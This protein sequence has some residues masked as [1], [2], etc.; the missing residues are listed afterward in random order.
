[1]SFLGLF[2]WP[3]SK[4][5]DEGFAT[6]SAPSTSTAK[7]IAQTMSNA[8]KTTSSSPPSSSSSLPRVSPRSNSTGHSSSNTASTMSASSAASTT[9]SSSTA[10]SSSLDDV[11][12][13]LS[14]GEAGAK[15]QLGVVPTLIEFVAEMAKMPE[16]WIHFPRD[17]ELVRL[18]AEQRLAADSREML[19]E[20]PFEMTPHRLQH[21]LIM[22]KLVPR[23]RKVRAEV[24]P[25][26]MNELR[27][28][29]IYFLLVADA[30]EKSGSDILLNPKAVRRA[31]DSPTRAA[32][33]ASALVPIAPDRWSLRT[34]HPLRPL[35]ERATE[36]MGIWEFITASEHA[37]DA[38]LDEYEVV[39]Y[40]Q[41]RYLNTSW[42]PEYI[43][44]RDKLLAFRRDHTLGVLARRGVPEWLGNGARNVVWRVACEIDD[45]AALQTEVTN[46][47]RRVFGPNVPA[48]CARIPTF[49]GWYRPDQHRTLTAP[50]I[51][52]SSR[53]L[54]ALALDNSNVA[55][56]PQLPDLCLVLMSHFDEFAVFSVCARLLRQSRTVELAL[57]RTNNNSNSSS[58]AATAPTV[59]FLACSV[60]AADAL[61]CMFMDIVE[62]CL[63]D[64][65]E[66]LSA[67]RIGAADFADAWLKRF[68]VD[69]LPVSVVW[70]IVDVFLLEG[71]S[72]LH[73][74]GVALLHLHSSMIFKCATADTLLNSLKMATR[75]FDN[76]ELLMETAYSCA[77]TRSLMKRLYT[78]HLNAD[79]RTSALSGRR[80]PKV[81]SPRSANISSPQLNRAMMT[82]SASVTLPPS[83]AAST[84]VSRSRTCSNLSFYR[85][86]IRNLSRVFT[87]QHFEVLWNWLPMQY[88][89][90][91]PTRIFSNEENG[92]SLTTFFVNCPSVIAPT[93]LLIRTTDGAIFGAYV[94]HGWEP[95]HPPRYYGNGETF[96]FRM[97]PQPVIYRW[98]HGNDELFQIATRDY[99][100]VGGNALWIDDEMWQGLSEPG[101]TFGNECLV[102]AEAHKKRQF[103]FNIAALEVYMFEEPGDLTAAERRAPLD[104]TPAPPAPPPPASPTPSESASSSRASSSASTASERG[105]SLVRLRTKIKLPS[106]VESQPPRSVT[107]SPRGTEPVEV[108]TRSKTPSLTSSGNSSGVTVTK[109][110]VKRRVGSTALSP[111]SSDEGSTSPVAPTAVS[112]DAAALRPRMLSDPEITLE[113]EPKP[114]AS[115]RRRVVSERKIKASRLQPH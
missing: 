16:T 91:E 93:L 36:N 44:H 113:S 83:T 57:L 2:R 49:G 75:A 25:R 52:A 13:P 84:A 47:Y 18:A 5:G 90:M 43:E 20:M 58:S 48:V 41:S 100:A 102:S 46:T 28:W 9:S 103:S 74:V 45:D 71:L 35:T 73:T 11:A 15:E 107:P 87:Q 53:I 72:V 66:H 26:H 30:L 98:T 78:T 111:R 50:Q 89:G 62:H 14:P 95:S 27:F 23:L 10:S 108:P 55:F 34:D 63:P 77:A 19:I 67:L 33:V 21:I 109:V 1:M 92:C 61:G 3:S 70:R 6:A 86:R 4:E 104:F 96:V 115:T 65:A 38:D 114:K 80:V 110:K 85:P 97:A 24:C 69:T 64:V 82:S 76:A 37:T 56:A 59:P 7:P 31:L 105:S 17:D 94:S 22:L 39:A 29:H 51:D 68:F 54:V 42:K 99:I 60:V 32:G 112:A 106:S 12:F 101:K 40:D 8:T 81:K 88:R 79:V